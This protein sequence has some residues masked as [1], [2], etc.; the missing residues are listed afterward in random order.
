[1]LEHQKKMLLGVAKNPHLF[2]KE[3]VKSFTWLSV[4]ELEALHK[5]VKK[6][7]GSYYDHLI[8]EIFCSISA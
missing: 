4:E 6:E 2:R 5:W 7:F 1:M 3:L 8:G